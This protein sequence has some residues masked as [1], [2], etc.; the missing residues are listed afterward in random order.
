MK[1]TRRFPALFFCIAALILAGCQHPQQNTDPT[2]APTQ[3]PAILARN[4]YEAAAEAMAGRDSY[5]LNVSVSEEMTVG[6][7]TF[8]SAQKQTITCQSLGSSDARI[9]VE[10][11]T[12]YGS[13]IGGDT[14]V[15]TQLFAA[16]QL[17]TTL[18]NQ[19]F[20][21]TAQEDT[22]LSQ[23]VPAVLL[24]SELYGEITADGDHTLVFSQPTGGERWL[25]PEE[26][27][28][29]SAEGTVQLDADDRLAQSDYT[30][31][32]TY[33]AASYTVTVSVTY[34]AAP[35]EPLEIPKDTEKMIS[36]ESP[37]ALFLLER[38]YGYLPQSKTISS[39][40]SSLVVSQAAAVTR[41]SSLTVERCQDDMQVDQ[42]ICLTDYNSGGQQFTNTLKEVFLDG[43]YTA[44]S[45]GGTPTPNASITK[46][47]MRSYVQQILLENLVS[48]LNFTGAAASDLGDTYLLEFTCGTEFG[49]AFGDSI[50]A[51]LF[52]DPDLLNNLA[53]NYT[54][55]A[56][57][58]Y[59]ALDKYSLLPTAAGINYV[60]THT[61][62]D[63]PYQL[64]VQL[65]QSFYP[66]SMTAREAITGE[67]PAETQPETPAKP[68]FYHV[69][70][71]DGQEMWLLGT[72]HIGDARTGFLP[73]TIYDAFD[74]SDALA[75]EFDTESFTQ[76]VETDEA[77]QAM[78]VDAYYYSDGSTAQAHIQDT[79]LYEQA[80]KRMKASGNYNFNTLYLKPSIWSNAIENF[81]LR[82]GYNLTADRGVDTRLLKLAQE[83]GKTI[84]DV[85]SAEFQIQMITGYSDALQELLLAQSVSATAS[86]YLQSVSELY[87]SWCAGDEAQLRELLAEEDVSDMTE[88]ELALYEEYRTAMETDRNAAM[89]EV[90]KGY[91]ESGDTV[92]YAVGLAHLLAEDG[93]V[94]TLRQ[95]GYRVELVTYP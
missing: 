6:Q 90:A 80:V 51:T 70:G 76:Q 41:N 26:A 48:P 13:S 22:F 40:T 9:Q 69:T 37:E 46:T 11:K 28:F 10:D 77:L 7:E 21:S 25:V 42:S 83:K 31:S 61:I 62:Y 54:T 86:E 4:R 91:L 60:G 45:D 89:L 50:C 87:E 39:A 79:E 3:D 14:T 23:I 71:Q 5:V 74:A 18:E 67:K 2:T 58:F 12:T 34:A 17:Y 82:Q 43:K 55:D 94:N 73:Q 88:E 93:L 16:G 29:L 20:I 27:Q 24:D 35:A 8:S 59:L 47:Q 64:T 66:A 38:A 33:G 53:T 78:I 49:K 92:F 63:A 1:R 44:A 36:L 56:M 75:V 81:I 68:L 65:D 32:F 19:D 15:S 57:E 85:E 30:A 95:A 52:E 84:L 72:I